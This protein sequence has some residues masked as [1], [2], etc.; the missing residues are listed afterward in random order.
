MGERGEGWVDRADAR[1]V[2]CPV[3]ELLSDGVLAAKVVPRKTTNKT[4]IAGLDSKEGQRY[5]VK[6]ET[7]ITFGSVSCRIVVPTPRLSVAHAGTQQFVEDETDDED[8]V[9]AATQVQAAATQLPTQPQAAT[10][11]AQGGTEQQSGTEQEQLAA[12]GLGQSA[13]ARAPAVDDG[14]TQAYG[15]SGMMEEEA[16]DE[17]ADQGEPHAGHAGG[18]TAAGGAT[19][20]GADSD[21]DDLPSA[22]SA[23]PSA[24][25]GAAPGTAHGDATQAGS[26][27][28]DEQ[29][30]EAAVR[31]RSA[32]TEDLPSAAAAKPEEL[33]K[34]EEPEKPPSVAVA[35]PT[36]ARSPRPAPPRSP[37]SRARTP[38]S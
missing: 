12:S 1:P 25:P 24:A 10:Q 8:A 20:R 14:A 23:A 9:C 6:N 16:E 38:T 4:R 11:H 30:Q 21:T 18:L 3:I 36:A 22:P 35:A 7:E 13:V 29:E 15:G 17:P 31:G 37:P 28:E 5:R 27:T 2:P 32:D 34:P 26:D 19:Q 33:E